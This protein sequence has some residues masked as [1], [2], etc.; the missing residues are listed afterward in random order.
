MTWV[1]GTATPI[2]KYLIF[3]NYFDSIAEML[4]QVEREAQSTRDE[5]SYVIVKHLT[6]S[7]FND[8]FQII[9]FYQ[10]PLWGFQQQMRPCGS[11]SLKRWS[12]IVLLNHLSISSWWSLCLFCSWCI[13]IMPMRARNIFYFSLLL[14]SFWIYSGLARFVFLSVVTSKL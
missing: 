9:E 2:P 3:E 14:M 10:N 4:L 13:W 1:S 7:D 12:I 8:W 6:L 11:S 5:G